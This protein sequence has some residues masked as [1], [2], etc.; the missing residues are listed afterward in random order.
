VASHPILQLL[1]TPP[2]EPARPPSAETRAGVAELF[3][4]AWTGGYRGPLARPAYEGAILAACACTNPATAERI[5]ETAI[6]SAIEGAAD[7]DQ[8]LL[9]DAVVPRLERSSQGLSVSAL[10]YLFATE[11]L[12][13]PLT[14]RHVEVANARVRL[15]RRQLQALVEF[16]VK[17]LCP[18]PSGEPP[19]WVLQAY[20][21]LIAQANRAHAEQRRRIQ[22]AREQDRK[23]DAYPPCIRSYL[24]KLR[25]GLHVN[26]HERFN[27]VAFL[28]MFGASSAEIIDLFRGLPGYS[29]S[30]T[31]YQVAHI[32]GRKNR[33]GPAGYAPMGCRQMRDLRICP[34]L[35][36]PGPTPALLYAR[37]L[38]AAK[39]T[40]AA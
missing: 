28:H 40:G 11:G 12:P 19:A 25:E 1:A 23:P 32:T 5:Q 16:H 8:Q 26:H 27:L 35:K 33:S 9:A 31:E 38:T 30:T 15:G 17:R 36:C 37:T 21:G 10:E 39:R 4:R 13:P 3:A 6:A 22:V 7:E 24:G 29:E 2:P 34:D 14:L 20:A 18:L